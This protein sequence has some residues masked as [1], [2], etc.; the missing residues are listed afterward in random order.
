MKAPLELNRRGLLLAGTALMTVG[1]AAP[2]VQVYE[3]RTSRDDG[4]ICCAGWATKLEETGRFSVTMLEAGEAPDF[5]RS[6][7]VPDG[8]AAC[9]TAMI[10]PYVIEGHVPADD[11]LRL[12]AEK[13]RDVLGLVVPGM[14]SGSPGMEQPNGAQDA[15]V[16]YAFKTGGVMEAFSHYPAAGPS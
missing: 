4:C 6:A 10:G 9:H 11:I 8:M 12:L 14:P 2:A 15:F 7:G 5:K 16:V 1:C 13:P 3:I